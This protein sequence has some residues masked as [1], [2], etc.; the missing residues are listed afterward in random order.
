[1]RPLKIYI[2]Y[3]DYKLIM[4]NYEIIKSYLETF[5]GD[6]EVKD[7]ISNIKKAEKKNKESLIN[8]QIEME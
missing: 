7:V 8:L 4:E 3:K 5:P 1:M 6:T 2:L